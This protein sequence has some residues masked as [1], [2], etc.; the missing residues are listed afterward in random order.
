VALIL[1][2]GAVSRFGEIPISAVDSRYIGVHTYAI[3]CGT[4]V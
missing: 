1:Q 3:Y 4:S 2:V